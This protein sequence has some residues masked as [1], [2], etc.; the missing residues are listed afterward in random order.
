MNLWPMTCAVRRWYRLAV[1][2]AWSKPLS[3]MI[4]NVDHRE[5]GFG[6]TDEVPPTLLDMLER[7]I[8]MAS[9]IVK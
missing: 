3:L 8:P 4:H 1:A 9:H 7:G 5:L 6:I 2:R